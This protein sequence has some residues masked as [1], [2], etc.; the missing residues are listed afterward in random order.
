MKKFLLTVSLFVI[1]L[2]ISMDYTKFVNAVDAETPFGGMHTVTYDSYVC[3]CG[4]N[5]HF[6]TDYTFNTQITLYKAP[7]SIIYSYYNTDGM[8][9]L[10]TYEPSGE[11]CQ[12]YVYTGCYTLQENVGTYGSAPG[13]GTT[14]E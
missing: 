9:Q 14:L 5:S 7:S 10:G 8:Y 11:P 1:I 3:T 12:V 2:L 13:T 4:G 6:I